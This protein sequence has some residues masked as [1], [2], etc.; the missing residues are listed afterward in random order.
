MIISFTTVTL[1]MT[2]DDNS[3]SCNIIYYIIY[4]ITND[5]TDDIA[6]QSKPLVL[7]DI[8]YC[9]VYYLRV[10]LMLAID[11][12]RTSNN[13]ILHHILGYNIYIVDGITKCE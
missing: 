1:M 10:T 2:I 7:T 3:R 8:V 11:D 13:I 4:D 12:N 6:M 9:I 5:I